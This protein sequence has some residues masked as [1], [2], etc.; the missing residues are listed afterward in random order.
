MTSRT[1][2]SAAVLRLCVELTEAYN[3]I[4]LQV[5]YLYIDIHFVLL[6]VEFDD[7]LSTSVS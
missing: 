4:I 5:W 7:G 3:I 1:L 2:E 6:H